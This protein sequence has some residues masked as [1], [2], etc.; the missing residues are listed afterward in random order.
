MNRRLKSIDIDFAPDSGSIEQ[1]I[2]DSSLSPFPQILD[3]ER[4]DRFTYNLLQGKVGILVEGSPFAIIAPITFGDALITVEDY[5]ARYQRIHVSV[6][7]PWKKQ[8]LQSTS[9]NQNTS[10]NQNANGNL[11]A[12]A[13]QNNYNGNRNGQ[14]N[15]NANSN[16]GNQNANSNQGNQTNSGNQNSQ[17]N[18]DSQDNQNSQNSQ[19]AKDKQNSEGNGQSIFKKVQSKLTK[20]Q[21]N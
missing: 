1:W 18:Q 4:P 19:N 21:N 3:T 17:G 20:D 5:N 8:D 15:Q 10:S 13:N 2:E 6:D 11:N 12:Q 9:G 7:P 16:E 14:G